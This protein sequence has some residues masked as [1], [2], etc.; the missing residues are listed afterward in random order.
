VPVDVL[1]QGVAE[2]KA[3]RRQNEEEVSR[4]HRREFLVLQ[5]DFMMEQVEGSFHADAAT[6]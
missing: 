5:P 3:R 4:V 6:S 1:R 2:A